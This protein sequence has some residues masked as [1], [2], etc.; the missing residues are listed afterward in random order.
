MGQ[1]AR[2]CL[3]V[4]LQA[5]V[6]EVAVKPVHDEEALIITKATAVAVAAQAQAVGDPCQVCRPAEAQE[7]IEEEVI[8]AL[9][10]IET[11]M[12][13]RPAVLGRADRLIARTTLKSLLVPRL[14]EGSLAPAPREAAT[15]GS[16]LGENANGARRR[17]TRSRPMRCERRAPREVARTRVASP[18][19]PSH[20][21]P[22]PWVVAKASNE[23]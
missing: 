9:H 20:L 13:S 12:A 5:A 1:V 3:V 4:D 21:R 17:S 16:S 7:G 18:T 11:S 22:R 10:E 2:E 19:R 14:L 15:T 6:A 8:K 23:P